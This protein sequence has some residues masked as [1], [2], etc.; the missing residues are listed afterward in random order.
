MGIRLLRAQPVALQRIVSARLHL[1]QRY[2]D[3]YPR[4]SGTVCRQDYCLD[5][6]VRYQ[7]L[8]DSCQ[9]LDEADP[10]LCPMMDNIIEREVNE[11]REAMQGYPHDR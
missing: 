7:E 9:A 6:C 11:N 8:S 2:F 5:T 10:S 3:G 1:I 4:R